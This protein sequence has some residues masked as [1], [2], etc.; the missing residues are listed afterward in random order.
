MDA[1]ARQW[2]VGVDWGTTQHQVCVV[3]ATGRVVREEGVAHTP[4][5]LGTWVTALVDRA[6]APGALAVA[7][8]VP[9][10]PVVELLLERGVPTYSISPRQVAAFRDRATV[11][12]AK[13]DR[14]DARVLAQAL[15]TDPACFRALAPEDPVVVQLREWSRL[16]AELTGEWQRLTNQLRAQWERFYAA[17]L[18]LSPAATDPWVWRLC[19][20]APTPAA[21]AGLAV[22][23]IASVVHSYRVRKWPPAA[24]QAVLQQPALVVAPGVTEAA[25]THARYLIARLWL[26]QQQR[27]ACTTQVAALLTTLTDPP[28]PPA[29]GGPTDA[30]I[31][32]SQPGVG[33]KVAARLLT[34]AAHLWPER[35]AGAL[36]A[37]M[38]LA[39]VTRQSGKTRL[40]VMRTA[41]HRPLRDAC[42]Y[43]ARAS[44]KCD[45]PSRAYYERLR[46]RGY[47]YGCALR[48]V[49]ERLLRILLAC[50]KSRTLYRLDHFHPSTTPC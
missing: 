10:G 18:T 42:F 6:G 43:W 4:E 11:A 33:P 35:L 40:V 8:E 19:E 20:R 32:R 17:L 29:D 44:L 47:T 25:S 15:R 45:P 21:G 1:P 49:A 26:V 9:R 28:D 23:V 27:E 30:A 50:L 37:W 41:C 16:D 36:R 34:E 24:V 46:A 3:D 14:R 22:D 39:P 2:W 12:G 5:A 7:I 38:G 31:M 48:A 13:D